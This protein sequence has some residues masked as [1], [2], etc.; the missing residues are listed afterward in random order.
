MALRTTYHF[1]VLLAAFG[2]LGAS[3]PASPVHVSPDR[4]T[5]RAVCTPASAGS[6][7]VDDVPAIRAAI[8]RC[9][10]GG[11]IV[12]PAGKTYML[13]SQLD[14]S[15][16]V[17][18]DFQ[19][20][21]RIKASDNLDY[22]SGKRYMIQIS[23]VKGAKFRSVTGT[24]EI[25]GNGQAAYDRFAADKSY[26]RP[27]LMVIQGGSSDISVS[28]FRV[29]N[30]PNVFFSTG[31]DATRL[32][33]SR[34]TLTA[35]SKS[36]NPPKNTD[37][38]DI[39]AA[40]HVTMTSISVQNQDD[41]IAFKPGINYLTVTD[42]TCDGSHGL[43][44]GSLGKAPGSVDTVQNIYVKSAIMKNSSKAAGIKIYPGGPLHGSAIVKNVT[45]DGVTI[46]NC[47]Y[48]FQYNACYNED[49]SY[50]KANPSPAQV[51]DIYI[52]N[53]SGTTSSKYAPTTVEV[54]CPVKGA[55]C[56]V[57]VSGWKVKSPKSDSKLLCDNISSSS[58]GTSCVD[59]DQYA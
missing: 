4:V 35:N 42:I 36:S 31:G 11:T 2:G 54:F 10:N 40:S 24:G 34:L 56:Q 1:L 59:T 38:F 25:D 39:G 53:F 12:L 21:G 50:C 55:K 32:S 6:A 3:T 27:T 48:A 8:T 58:L 46:D 45:W 37:G 19:L 26:K 23:G 14:F 7:T 41:C 43:S 49:E 30:A 16:C 18:C 5:K 9:G 57:H 52:K 28:N 33:F 15:G 44:V 13:R 47:D 20:E 29:K 17:N 51:T 22:W